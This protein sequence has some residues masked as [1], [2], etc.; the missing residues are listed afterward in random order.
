MRAAIVM[1]AVC[2]V[3]IAG[4]AVAQTGP[5]IPV[6]DRSLSSEGEIVVYGRSLPQIGLALSGSQ[7]VVGYRDFEDRPL[8]RV[9]ELVE[10]VPGVIAT[11]HSGTG[12]ANQYFLRGFN[13]DHGTDFAGF[14]DG[15]PVN[16]RTHGHGQGYLDLNFLIPELV[17]RI[18]YRKG[19]YFADTGDF[20]AAGTVKFTTVDRLHAPLIE[21]TV[22]SFGYYRALAA[23]SASLGDGHL[24][25]A[26]DGTLSD[27]PWVL[28]ERLR[29]VNGLVKY[30]AGDWSLGL[31]GYHATWA[32]TDQVPQ[33]AVDSGLIGRF[34]NIDPYLGGTTTRIGL[35]ATGRAADTAI[36]LYTIAYSFRLTSNFTY[37][38]DDPVNGDEFQQRDRR[39]IFGG[40]LAR[41]FPTTIGRLPVT[42]TLGS[43]GRYDAIGKIGLYDSI[44]G[45]RGAPVRQDKVDEASGALYGQATV[46]PTDRLRLTLGLRGD[47]YGYKVR[48]QTLAANSGR[49]TD[50]ILGPNAALA[51]RAADHLELY[52]NYGE[53]FHSNDARGATIR[54]DP[55]TGDPADRVQLLVKARG[56]EVGARYERSRFSASLVAY[57]LTLGSELVFSGDGGTTEPNDATR[58][59]GGE[60][61]L[62]WRPLAWLA[63]DGSAALSHARFRGVAPG[64]TRIPNSASNVLSLGAAIDLPSGLSASARLRHFGAAPLIEDNT[65]RSRATT[66][67][68]LGTYYR[69]GRFKLGVDLLNAFGSKDND[70]TYFYASRLQGEAAGGVEDYHVHPVEPRQ[71]RVSVRASF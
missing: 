61:T 47:L 2:L 44:A 10:N 31:T 7:G 65:A 36:N 51:W 33:R 20:S 32:A 1:A 37:F 54:I 69:V 25:A 39:L 6:I 50:F 46:A 52:A 12:K 22:G 3:G 11:Q 26:I 9:G 27:G 17:E 48:A 29:K 56:S 28:D 68:N 45:M 35:T 40:S 71:V 57:Y 41:D 23:G 43:E 30:T 64:R 42:V 14:V 62:F 49:G 53:S 38:L 24:L 19:P 5:A 8:S 34:G 60:A 55:V 70:I 21:A 58:R 18:D 15:A 13:L 67:V 59:Y 16:M 4:D 63:L 66:L